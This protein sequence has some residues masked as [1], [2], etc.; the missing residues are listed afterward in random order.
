M[1]LK[2]HLC[3][4]QPQE[5]QKRPS[6]AQSTTVEQPSEAQQVAYEERIVEMLER[7]G[8]A[9]RVVWAQEEP[10]NMGP[11]TFVSPLLYEL[12]SGREFRYAGRAEAASPA[13]GSMRI[14]KQE[15]ARLLADA[16][17]GLE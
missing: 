17:D 6:E 2:S 8:S 13:T 1:N 15:Q 14:H 10:R 12:V 4:K 11:W 16:F 3:P 5:T 9:S 7:Y